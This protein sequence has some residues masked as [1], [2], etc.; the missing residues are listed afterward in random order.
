MKQQKEVAEFI[1][2]RNWN[3]YHTPKELLLGMVEEI[4]EFRNI[5]KW[6]RDEDRVLKKIKD[7]YEEIEDF[8]GDMLWELSS[9]ANYC[10][11][12]LDQALD[13]V[14]KKHEIRY[15]VEAVKDKHT[16]E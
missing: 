16:N 1:K 14:I 15:P 10:G 6:E 3:K 5:I 2:E 12:D 13:K 11:V 4:G 9:L 8:F 7:N